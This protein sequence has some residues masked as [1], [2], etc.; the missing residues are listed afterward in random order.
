M[1]KIRKDNI[2]FSHNKHGLKEIETTIYRGAI[3]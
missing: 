2:C 3:Q 1:R